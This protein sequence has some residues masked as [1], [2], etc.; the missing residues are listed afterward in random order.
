MPL[1]QEK[2]TR[3]V[4]FGEGSVGSKAARGSCDP[5]F[6]PPTSTSPTSFLI[7]PD[8]SDADDA[9]GRLSRASRAPRASR[10]SSVR[11]SRV[12]QRAS[13]AAASVR[14]SA[15]RGAIDLNDE[16]NAEV[17]IA[18][19]LWRN[20]RLLP[21]SSASKRRW[22]IMILLFVFYSSVV[23]PMTPAFR[24][25]PDGAQARARNSGRAIFGAR[26]QLGAILA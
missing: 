4:Q 22:D 19:H 6:T 1:E 17:V 12:V 23:Y 21:P 14:R 16:L 5:C 24:L 26:A 13:S 15:S 11:E 20:H 2:S 9:N 7:A 25:T 3:R 8:A 10:Y 18:R